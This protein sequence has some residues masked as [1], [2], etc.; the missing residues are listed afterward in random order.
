MKYLPDESAETV[1]IWVTHYQ[2]AKKLLDQISDVY[3]RRL[4]KK[5][6]KT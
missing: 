5:C 6:I 1:R 3:W 4:E 2:E